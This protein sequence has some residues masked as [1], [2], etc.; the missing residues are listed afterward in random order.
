MCIELFGERTPIYS[1]ILLR[2]LGRLRHR[3][4]INVVGYE[5]IRRNYLKIY[6]I[7]EE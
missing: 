1:R 7:R 2:D 4:V 6:G 3:N 5:G